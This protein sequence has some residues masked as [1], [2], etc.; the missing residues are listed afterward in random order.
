MLE[1]LMLYIPMDRR[2]AIAQGETLLDRT[3]GAALF[4][5]ISGFTPLTAALVRELGPQ[6]GAEELT[7]SLNLIFDVVIEELHRYHGSV[8]AFAGDAITCWLDGDDGLR[9]TN[10]ALAMQ[11][12]L[13]HVAAIRTPAGTEIQLTMKSAVATGPVRRFLVGDPDIRVLDVVAGET[14]TRLATAEHQANRGEVIVDAATLDHI[15]HPLHMVDIRTDAETGRRFG[16]VRGP[17]QPHIE[18][19]WPA[20]D[21]S[22]VDP[23]EI[24]SWLLPSVFKQITRG[25]QE[26]SAD[27]RSTVALFLRFAGIAYDGDEDA[28]LKLDAYFRWVQHIVQR[29][30]GTLIDLNIGDKGNYI[31]INFGAPITHENNAARAAYAA[32]ALLQAPPELNFIEPV[33][34]GISQGYMRA[35]VYGGTNHRTYGVLGDQ[36]NMAARL[37]TKAQPGQA[38]VSEAAHRSIADAFRFEALPPMEVKGKRAPITPYSLLGSREAQPILSVTYQLPMI[39]R[40]AELQQIVEQLALAAAGKGQIVALVGD[41]GVG[42]SRLVAEVTR[43]AEERAWRTVGGACESYG[44]NSSY[45]VWQPIWRALFDLTTMETPAEQIRDLTERVIAL[46]PNWRP[47]LPLL[48]TVLQLPIPD[49]SLTRTFDAKLRKTSL[50]SLLV[51]ILQTLAAGQP[52]LIVL[53]DCHWL[54]AISSD[55]LMAIGH[56]IA[57]SPICILMTYRKLPA[58]QQEALSSFPYF[59]AHQLESFSSAEATALIRQKFVQLTGEEF[60][61]EGKLIEQLVA[62]A[63]GNPFYLEELVNYLHYEGLSKGENGTTARLVLPDSLHR[64]VLS[65]LDQ[66]TDNQKSIMR[67]AS[68]MGRV[69]QAAWLWGVYPLLGDAAQV[70]DDLAVLHQQ[71]LTVVDP[72]EPELTYFFKQVITQSVTYENLPF[73]MR[74]ALHNQIGQFIERVYGDSLAK[75]LDLLAYH[76][77]RSENAQKRRDYLLRAGEAA[78]AQYANLAAIDYYTRVLPLLP[79]SARVEVR[80]KLGRVLE[81]TGQWEAAKTH[82]LQALETAQALAHPQEE[83]WCETAIAELLRKQGQYGEA[84]TWLAQARTKFE[85]VGDRAGV[86]QVLHYAGTLADQQGDFEQARALYLESL[87]IRRE[88]DDQRAIGSLLSNLGIVARRRG[89]LARAQTLYGESLAIRRALGDKWAL[90]ISLNNLGNVLLDLELLDDARTHLAEA[91]ALQRDVG[92]RGMLGNAL[93]NLGNVARAQGDYATARSLY[94]ESLT[95]Y[96]E[97]NDKWALAYLLEDVGWLVARQGQGE[98]AL[99]LLGAAGVLRDSIGAPLSTREQAKLDAAVMPALTAIAPQSQAAIIAAGQAMSL[100]QAIDYALE[101]GCR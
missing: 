11:E 92:D 24:R 21:V 32:L 90:A 56:A 93:N 39:S 73:A 64:L 38:L 42:K 55:L 1:D 8:I 33:Q 98:T 89:D 45:L 100:P 13:R 87:A 101:M 82:Y 34:I 58:E 40:T 80:L 51:E 79:E 49:N 81:L 35:G 27:L 96:R 3:V 75:Y 70:R 26:F 94:G 29:Y 25:M 83:A 65:R 88:L 7:N 95:I 36:V 20:L 4:T 9:A 99:R 50:E 97:L 69:F 59:V 14:L 44:T 77:D 19:P 5:D 23:D 85:E 84:S 57:D 30:G 68:V 54:D 66:L 12:A 71:N 63:Q 31:Y 61:V 18:S 41:A 74:S 10:C 15:A 17:E 37:M 48:D 53:E 72:A 52:T 22:A 78:Q 46:N 91:V 67:V 6:R 16:V 43:A 47:R 2:H 86:G 62:Q 76:Y 28:G 60:G